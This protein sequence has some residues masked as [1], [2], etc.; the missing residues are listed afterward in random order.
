[1]MKSF[2]LNAITLF[3]TLP[4]LSVAANITNQVGGVGPSGSIKPYYCIQNSK[5][6]VTLP[7]APGQS[8]DGNAASGNEYYVGGALRFNGC[9][10]ADSYLGYLGVSLNAAGNNSISSYSP[11]GSGLHVTYSNP[12]IDSK[13]MLSGTI[14][15]TPIDINTTLVKAPSSIPTWTYAGINL[16]GLEFDKVVNA[17]VIPN[18]SITDQSTT[19][20]DLANTTSFIQS[21]INTVR[22]PVSWDYLQMDGAGKGSISSEYYVNFVR[23]LIATLTQ[24][25]VYTIIDMHAYM[26]YSIYGEQYSG[27][28]VSG[29]CPDGTLVVDSA[30]YQSVWGQVLDL[31]QNDKD[32]DMNYVMLDLMNEPVSVPNDSVFTIQT[33]LIKYLRGKNFNGP[34]LVEGNAWTGLHSW[35]TEAWTGSDGKTYTNATLFTKDN[36][37]KAGIEDLSKIF[38]NVHQYLDSDY[39]GTH[40]ECQADLN[41]TGPNGFNLTAFVDYLKANQLKAMVTE[42]GA[43]TN[44]ASCSATLKQFMQYLK[45]NA[46]GDKNYGF[47]G[48]TVW[49]TGHGWGASYNLLVTPTSYQWGVLSPFLQAS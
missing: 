37:S 17:F 48:W 40:N 7:L 25:H 21:G 31:L 41:T 12:S 46:V 23:P 6:Q 4:S 10:A 26:R 2:P 43:G 44:S 42:F 5:N 30:A 47:A 19:A 45:D 35:T 9:T 39:S 29:P 24:A 15:F 32:I 38:I 20:S 49:S 18:L 1:M 28:G 13:G 22:V 16:A 14:A 8:G 3:L 11:P 36:F 27:C 33:D 34:I